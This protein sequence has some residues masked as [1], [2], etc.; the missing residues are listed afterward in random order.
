M[1]PVG[2]REPPLPSRSQRPAGGRDRKKK[3]KTKNQQQQHAEDALK[4]S[5][6]ERETPRLLSIESLGYR[7][8]YRSPRGPFSLV[9]QTSGLQS[10]GSKWP[11]GEWVVGRSDSGRGD[12]ARR[13]KGGLRRCTSLDPC[14]PHPLRSGNQEGREVKAQRL[15]SQLLWLARSLGEACQLPGTP[16]VVAPIRPRRPGSIHVRGFLPTLCPALVASPA[17]PR[18]A[19]FSPAL[20]GLPFAP[21]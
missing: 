4:M 15:E 7:A 8:D 17:P 11:S 18:S 12:S 3:Q 13:E 19:L 14:H 9:S 5:R 16:Q 2:R 6:G 10:L 1:A 21:L 20:A